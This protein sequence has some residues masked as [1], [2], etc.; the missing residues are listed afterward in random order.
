MIPRRFDRILDDCL[1]RM[2]RGES[3]M[4]ILAVYPTQAE[5]IKPLLLV[6]MLSRA[7]PQPV[8]GYTALREGKNQL[9]AEMAS[10]QAED[11]FLKPKPVQPPRERVVDR[12]IGSLKSLQPVYRFATLA[13]VVFLTGGFFT[14]SASASGLADNIMHT[15]YYSFEQVGDLLLVKPAAPKPVGENPIF[16]SDYHLPDSPPDYSGGYKSLRVD[17]DQKDKNKTGQSG[18]Q[19]PAQIQTRVYSFA[20]KYNGEEVLVEAAEEEVELL[21]DALDEGQ[22]DVIDDN[23]QE[24]EEKQEEKE[25]EK[26]IKEEEKEAEK[27]IKE[28]EKEAEKVT[29]E[30]EKEDKKETKEE[31]KDEKKEAKE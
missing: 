15:L 4:D 23:D 25:A 18:E 10:M 7:L 20:E 31:E 1:L 11:S 19:V 9:L 3:L 21:D 14:L 12:W 17:Q 6:A 24:K 13:L 8:P 30:D 28:E 26:V 27:V 16:S 22:V 5:K 2:D 29:K